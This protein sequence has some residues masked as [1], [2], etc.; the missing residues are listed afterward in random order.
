MFAS[1]WQ[2][3]NLDIADGADGEAYGDLVTTRLRGFR[4]LAATR[5]GSA[6]VAAAL[7]DIVD[8]QQPLPMRWPVGNDAVHQIPSARR[9]PRSGTSCA[10]PVPSGWRTPHPSPPHRRL[11][12]D[13]GWCWSWRL[14]GSA[15]PPPRAGGAGQR[16][17]HHARSD[18]TPRRW[19]TASRSASTRPARRHRPG[20]DGGA[21]TTV[22][23][24][25]QLD[26]LVNNAGYGL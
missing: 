26:I 8:L 22:A 13:E 18:R 23:R 11:R 14:G 15:P 9:S 20:G 25:G 7:A 10:A 17:G 12:V 4:E 16:G 1:D 21:W 6:S 19:W 3:A 5:P 2:T 24:F